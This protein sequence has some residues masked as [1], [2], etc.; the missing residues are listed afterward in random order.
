MVWRAEIEATPTENENQ[1]NQEYDQ[2]HRSAPIEA[3]AQ[4]LKKAPPTGTSTGIIVI[5]GALNRRAD[6][7][8]S[9]VRSMRE[10]AKV[11]RG[12]SDDQAS[13]DDQHNQCRSIKKACSRLDRC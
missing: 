2:P 11:D 1:N 5:V 4:Y 10:K 8:S 12:K 7:A 3:R 9:Q 13:A 6:R